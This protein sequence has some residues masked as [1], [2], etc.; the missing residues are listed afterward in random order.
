MENSTAKLSAQTRTEEQRVSICSDILLA[1]YWQFHSGFRFDTPISVK[2]A[3]LLRT[4]ISLSDASTS[5]Y[6]RPADTLNSNSPSTS[7]DL[8]QDPNASLE[9]IYPEAS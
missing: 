7:L 3:K 9:L 2:K 8:L 1:G 5:S 6:Y 4:P